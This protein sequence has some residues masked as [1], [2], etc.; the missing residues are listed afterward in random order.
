MQ[1]IIE[2]LR[3]RNLK[4]AVSVYKDR[5]IDFIPKKNIF[6]L[7]LFDME[8][9]KQINFDI[10]YRGIF[11]HGSLKVFLVNSNEFKKTESETVNEFLEKLKESGGFTNKTTALVTEKKDYI[12]QHELQHV[13]D[14]IIRIKST[15]WEYEYRAYLA[16]LIY[17]ENPNNVLLKLVKYVNP[18]ISE[19]GYEFFK[20]NL[21]KIIENEKKIVEIEPHELSILKIIVDLD[22]EIQEFDEKE[23]RMKSKKL[24]NENYIKN[25]GGNYDEIL[26]EL[27]KLLERY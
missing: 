2:G 8:K 25:V 16:S 23:I 7:S 10:P 21:N 5:K 1:D 4:R 22:N 19:V 20:H 3:K 27:E 12:I 24:M 18:A 6:K 14:N 26:E 11:N 15:L 17:S 13:F 9:K